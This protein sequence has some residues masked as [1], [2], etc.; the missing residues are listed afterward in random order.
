MARSRPRRWPT[1]GGATRGLALLFLFAASL[2]P[3]V[4]VVISSLKTPSAFATNYFLPDFGHVHLDNYR[5]AAIEVLPA[6]WNSV[7]VSAA[8]VALVLICGVPAAYA[9]AWRRF[10]GQRLIYTVAITTM[11]VPTVLT[12]VP[13]FILVRDLGLIDTRWSMVLPYTAGTVGLAVFLLRSFFRAV[14]VE[15]VEAAKLDG[16]SDLRVL[17]HVVLPLSLPTLA[18]LVTL[19]V[20]WTWNQFLWPLV[21][22]SSEDQRPV[23]VALAF[24]TG[25]RYN[26]NYPQLMAGYVLSALPLVVVLAITMRAFIRGMLSGALKA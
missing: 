26:V 22:V 2:Y 16:S 18:T 20:L 13:M 8:T 15:L 4:F 11:M 7:V 9:L 6:V 1:P 17:W 19:N 3:I 14:P 23:P 25:D 21:T 24:L 10:R 12:F 5:R